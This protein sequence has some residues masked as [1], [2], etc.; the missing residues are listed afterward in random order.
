[1]TDDLIS[2]LPTMDHAV[3][4]AFITIKSLALDTYSIGDRQLMVERGKGGRFELVTVPVFMVNHAELGAYMP[5]KAM[6]AH[7]KV[8]LL[9]Y[10][11]MDLPGA[12]RPFEDGVFYAW[13]INW[14]PGVEVRYP[15]L[16]RV[17]IDQVVCGDEIKILFIASSGVFEGLLAV[18]E[19]KADI[20]EELARFYQTNSY[21][22][23]EWRK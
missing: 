20:E 14:T 17:F 11:H 2:N 23:N 19:K 5:S 22:S 9:F 6:C 12:I 18:P 16:S 4:Q 21:L 3:D 8:H 7:G 13:I 1:M 15:A 10:T